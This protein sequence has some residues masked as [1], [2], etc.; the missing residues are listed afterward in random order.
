MKWRKWKAGLVVAGVSGILSGVMGLTFAREID[1]IAFAGALVIG[2]AKDMALF[3][4]DHPIDAVV[5]DAA[6]GNPS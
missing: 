2:A 4:K 5:D 1:W 6:P 3:L